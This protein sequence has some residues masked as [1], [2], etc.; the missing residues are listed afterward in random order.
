MSFVDIKMPTLGC[1]RC[2]LVF[3]TFHLL[4]PRFFIKNE[5]ISPSEFLLLLAA[6]SVGDTAEGGPESG[7]T[8]GFAAT[9]LGRGL[10]RGGILKKM[11][12]SRDVRDWSRLAGPR[13]PLSFLC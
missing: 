8:T 5:S 10:G 6:S 13:T 2:S 12:E 7:W 3:K 11:L 1:S 4:G 9:T